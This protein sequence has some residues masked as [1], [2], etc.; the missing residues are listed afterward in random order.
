MRCANYWDGGF[1]DDGDV[2][3]GLRELKLSQ[4]GRTALL[5]ASENGHA[6]CVRLL[7]DAGANKNATANVRP[8]FA[9]S[10]LLE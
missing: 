4:Y 5:L 2:L 9:A 7:L 3:S 10:L 1:T 6:Q 8:R